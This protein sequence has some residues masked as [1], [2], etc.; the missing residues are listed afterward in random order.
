[1]LVEGLGN[2]VQKG[3]ED[4]NRL[5]TKFRN[6]NRFKGGLTNKVDSKQLA[7]VCTLKLLFHQIR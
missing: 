4:R 6:R 1:M 3:S 7:I 2:R 5:E